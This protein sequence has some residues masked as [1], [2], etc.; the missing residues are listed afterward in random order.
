MTEGWKDT[1]RG[2]EFAFG[3]NVVNDRYLNF[4]SVPRRYEHCVD[5]NTALV[6]IE[7]KPSLLSDDLIF[8]GMLVGCDGTIYLRIPTFRFPKMDDS[9]SDTFTEQVRVPYGKRCEVL[10]LDGEF[11]YRAVSLLAEN[12][13]LPFVQQQ[14]FGNL[15]NPLSFRIPES[16]CVWNVFV[17]NQFSISS[18]TQ[19]S[20]APPYFGWNEY[21]SDANYTSFAQGG[22]LDY[23]C[24]RDPDEV[25]DRYAVWKISNLIP[26]DL[27][28]NLVGHVCD[29]GWNEV[30]LS[31]TC[32]GR[33]VSELVVRNTVFADVSSQIAMV[34]KLITYVKKLEHFGMTWIANETLPTG[35]G[36]L[37]T[38]PLLTSL[39]LSAGELT[40]LP[41]EIGKLTSLTK[42]NLQSNELAYLP[43]EIGRLTSL[44]SLNLGYNDLTSIPSE[45]GSL[46]SLSSLDLRWNQLTTLPSEIRCLGLGQNLIILGDQLLVLDHH[47]NCTN[48]VGW[49]DTAGHGCGWYEVED[50]CSSTD[51]YIDA[52]GISAN[53]ACCFCGGGINENDGE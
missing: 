44:S 48:S 22:Q 7:V 27:S 43:S 52:D 19:W 50:A 53:E 23:I 33:R 26:E 14:A 5:P 42:L 6:S 12:K 10:F 9:I 28:Q 46:T 8:Q 39:D 21:L 45:I 17:E 38:L 25:L 3:V 24:R 20:P 29:G 13:T 35:I 37:S 15:L 36:L 47:C 49:V 40:S 51:L 31:V 18:F 16:S 41:S 32:S 11:G 2:R 34:I 30:V 1:F 4:D